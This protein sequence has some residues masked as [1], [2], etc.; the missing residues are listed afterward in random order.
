MGK[1]V[2]EGFFS[3]FVSLFSSAAEIRVRAC[4]RMKLPSLFLSEGIFSVRHDD[5]VGVR[6]TKYL[7]GELFVEDRQ[8]KLDIKSSRKKAFHMT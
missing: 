4:V 5:R 1:K 2:T 8:K 6:R 3:A 7:S